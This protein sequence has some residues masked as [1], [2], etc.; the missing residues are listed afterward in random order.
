MDNPLYKRSQ[1][2]GKYNPL[3][4]TKLV[5]NYRAHPNL[6]A[7][8]SK[9]FYDNELISASVEN[10]D[11]LCHTLPFLPKRGVPLLFHGIRGEQSRDLDS[12]SWYN[13]VEVIQV[14][15]YVKNLLENHCS[16]DDIGIITPY[17]KQVFL[18]LYIQ[19]CFIFL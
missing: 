17:R 13:H 4:L 19:D 10:L 15:Q 9:L 1:T 5:R 3:L 16:S 7:L 8:P 14:V 11:E 18:A 2:D 6:L 12:P